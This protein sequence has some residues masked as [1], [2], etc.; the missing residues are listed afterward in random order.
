MT[1]AKDLLRFEVR[2]HLGYTGHTPTILEC[3]DEFRGCLLCSV[4]AA[5]EVIAFQDV[6]HHADFVFVDARIDGINCVEQGV[7]VVYVEE[8]GD[9][10]AFVR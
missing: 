9:G 1:I 5:L 4:H 3:G 6:F 10:A 7:K 8:D 2:E